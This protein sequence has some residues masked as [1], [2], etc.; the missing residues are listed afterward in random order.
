[1]PQ[2]S[3]YGLD[4]HGIVNSAETIWNQGA[5]SL[6]E[7]TIRA[8]LGTL[9]QGGA[10][11]VNT[12]KYTGRSAND[13]FLVEEPSSR[14][15]IWWGPVNKPISPDRFDAMQANFMQNY[16]AMAV[17]AIGI[18]L[19]FKFAKRLLRKPLANVNRNLMKPLGI[20]VKL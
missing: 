2:I 4:K 17:S 19:T 12:G 5:E 13:K 1:M 7:A 20:G 15:N 11:S 18:G 9:A 14:D 16:R 3:K 8:G 6:Y 10:L